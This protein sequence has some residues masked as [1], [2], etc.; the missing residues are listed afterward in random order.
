MVKKSLPGC[1]KLSDYKQDFLFLLFCTGTVYSVPVLSFYHDQTRDRLA[2]KCPVFHARSS[3]PAAVSASADPG[4]NRISIVR[5][6]A[7][8]L[9]ARLI[10]LRMMSRQFVASHRE[11]EPAMLMTCR[12]TESSRSGAK[13][14]QSPISTMPMTSRMIILFLLT[15]FSLI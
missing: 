10:L 8:S 7:V 9:M 14:R 2:P 1:R 12:N 13:R 5:Y 3:F 6:C 11:K 4:S 15:C